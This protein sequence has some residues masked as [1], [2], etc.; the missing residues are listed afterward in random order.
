MW[1]KHLPEQAAW[2]KTKNVLPAKISIQQLAINLECPITRVELIRL[3]FLLIPQL[4][5]RVFLFERN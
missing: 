4:Y 3:K 5:A 1:Q 2:N